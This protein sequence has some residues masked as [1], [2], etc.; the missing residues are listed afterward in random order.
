MS[1]QIKNSISQKGFLI[2]LSIIMMSCNS[3]NK[4]DVIEINNSDTPET[5]LVTITK[6]QFE[7]SNM[8]LGS[9]SK[10]EFNS[11][12]KANGMFDVPPENK[13]TVSAY[14][15]GYVKNIS[16]LPGD[17]VKKGQVLFTLENPEYVQMQQ[18]FLEAQSKLD[19]LKADYDRQQTLLADNITSKKS[20]LKA[21]SEY[22]MTLAQ[23]QSLKKKLGLMNINPNTLSGETITSTISVLAPI[24]GT[25]TSIEAS[26]GMF[27]NPSD[28]A[29]TVTNTN[30]LHLELKIFEQDL[31][32]VKEGQPIKI[33]LL[34]N[35]DSIYDG[36]V[37][38]INKAVNTEDRTINIHGDLV[39]DK[40]A[41]LFAPGMYIET[42][43]ITRSHLFDALPNEAIV[44]IENAFYALT[45][46][47]ETTYKKVPIAVGLSSNGFTQILNSND[48]N[49]KTEFVTKGAFN[50]IT[51]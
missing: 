4:Q 39:N 16:L 51:E 36:E 26:K 41:N 1:N 33:H 47:D 18:D 30:H 13:A 49:D 14:F 34:N 38:L 48:F 2:I 45:K 3:K 40:D 28:V 35:S 44:N 24:S 10:Q 27:L 5:N 22:K 19:Y 29:L 31:P 43:I 32:L 6:S 37:H 42:D 17:A 20:F 50:L 7:S 46:Q 23:Y 25:V 11:S 21:E 12:V 15:A 8:K 9:I